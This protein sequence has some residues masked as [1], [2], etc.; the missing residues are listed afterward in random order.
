MNENPIPLDFAQRMERQRENRRRF[1]VYRDSTGE[2][3]PADVVVATPERVFV[4]VTKA[5]ELME[6]LTAY[7]GTTRR[8]PVFDAMQT[9]TLHQV[10]GGW[11]DGR[12]V[13]V[14][15]TAVVH[16]D[17]PVMQD[18][19]DALVPSSSLL[20]VPSAWHAVGAA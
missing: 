10:S 4:I 3:L 19:V 18:L 7:G 13:P 16:E 8:G 11:S 20:G 15:I 5:D 6:W 12:D 9:W 17:E 14:Q 2:H 1:E